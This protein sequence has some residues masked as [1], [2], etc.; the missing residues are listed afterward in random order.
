M[1][2]CIYGTRNG[3]NLL[4]DCY[5]NEW[6]FKK[7]VQW[8]LVYIVQGVSK[9]VGVALLLVKRF[10]KIVFVNSCIYGTRN[11]INHFTCCTSLSF[12]EGET[13]YCSDFDFD[14]LAKVGGVLGR[15]VFALQVPAF[16]GALHGHFYRIIPFLRLTAPMAT[17]QHFLLITVNKVN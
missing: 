10:K 11:G 6:S 8:H 13:F 2:S 12:L 16:V 4:K 9:L 3:V 5:Y 15:L 17:G 1:E 14:N 7:Q